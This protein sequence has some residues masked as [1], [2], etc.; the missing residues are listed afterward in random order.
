MDESASA[1]ELE[2]MNRYIEL[3]F[4]SSGSMKD[5]AVAYGTY[6]GWCRAV[7]ELEWD[8]FLQSPQHMKV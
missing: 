8:I 1:A 5:A 4:G 2:A 6:S 3:R 7:M